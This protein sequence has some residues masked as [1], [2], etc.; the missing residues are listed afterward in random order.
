MFKKILETLEKKRE[1]LL[2]KMLL[3]QGKATDAIRKDMK[4]GLLT[5]SATTQRLINNGFKAEI[6]TMYASDNLRAFKESLRKKYA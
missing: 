3:V 6:L 4:Q 5:N 1:S 2:K